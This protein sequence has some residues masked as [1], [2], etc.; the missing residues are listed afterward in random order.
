MK[1]QMRSDRAPF[2]MFDVMGEVAVGNGHIAGIVKACGSLHQFVAIRVRMEN[3][4]MV[5]EVQVPDCEDRGRALESKLRQLGVP[6]A[7]DGTIP[8]A[9][10]TVR[11]IGYEGEWVMALLPFVQ[12]D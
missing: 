1:K 11:L 6:V 4:P 10:T 12:G 8:T 5:G 2:I 3:K 9:L 7:G